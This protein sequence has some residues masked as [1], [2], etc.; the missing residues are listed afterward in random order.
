[1][2]DA[3]CLERESVFALLT[4]RESTELAT[5]LMMG[6]RP[7]DG[8]LALAFHYENHYTNKTCSCWPAV[9]RQMKPPKKQV[10]ESADTF[11]QLSLVYGGNLI[12]LCACALAQATRKKVSALLATTDTGR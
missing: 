4:W 6:R 8:G 2:I 7:L 9:E 3:S 10:Y 1:M 5:T 11:G 12:A